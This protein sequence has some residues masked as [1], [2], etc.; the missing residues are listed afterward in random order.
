MRSLVK[1]AG[2]FGVAA[3]LL[4]CST[5]PFFQPAP[6]PFPTATFT[7]LPTRTVAPSPTAPPTLT[8]VSSATA[9][10][11]T[12]QATPTS[13]GADTP[14]AALLEQ[15]KQADPDV[16]FTALRLAYIETEDYDPYDFQGGGLKQEMYAALNAED[17]ETTLELVQQILETNYVS[18]DTHLAALLAYEGL[19]ETEQAEFHRYVLDGLIDSVLASGDGTSPETAFVVIFVE[20]EYAILSVL[21]IERGGQSLVEEDG[22]RFD[23]FEGVDNATNEAVTVYFIVDLVFGWLTNSL[24][25]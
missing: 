18:M 4:S 7:P 8:P 3:L 6:T 21:G 16:D 14:Y 11:E 22:H 23:K 1:L 17:Y 12:P 19:G 15:V 10:T 24:T 13:Q 2:L 5:L 25:P 9:A 20:E